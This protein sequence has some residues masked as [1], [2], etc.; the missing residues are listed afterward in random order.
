MNTIRLQ[1]HTF[2]AAVKNDFCFK[3]PSHFGLKNK[4]TQN[5]VQVYFCR[6]QIPHFISSIA[7]LIFSLAST[8][9]VYFKS[10][11]IFILNI[12]ARI[13]VHFSN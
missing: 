11:Q 13:L 5:L 8:N 1:L 2:R 12:E 9:H 4:L 7:R 10:L 6:F 3:S